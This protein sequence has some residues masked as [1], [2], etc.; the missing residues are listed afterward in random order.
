M[1][2]SMLFFLILGDL[3][4]G[5]RDVTA[6][7]CQVV[8]VNLALRMT[9]QIVFEQPPSLTL[10]ADE[11]H[12]KIRTNEEAKRSIAIIP[13]IESSTIEQVTSGSQAQNLSQKELA[14]RLDEALRTNLFVFFNRSNQLMFEL[15]FV[16]KDKA[17]YIVNVKQD[18]NQECKI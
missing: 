4:E 13:H 11:Q 9:T 2:S 3:P 14:K 6:T 5:V 17:D 16:E 1:I 18:F 15:R 12:F 7:S 8:R 10:H